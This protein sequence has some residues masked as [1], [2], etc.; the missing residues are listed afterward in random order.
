[1]E[2]RIGR[3]DRIGQKNERVLVWNYVYDETIEENIYERLGERISLFEQAVGPLRPILEGIEG[4]VQSIAMGESTKSG[5]DVATEAEEQSKK[6]EQ[7]VRQVGL[8]QDLDEI[9]PKDIIEEAKLYGWTSTHPDVGRIGYPGRPFDSLVTPDVLKRLFTQ[10]Q[11]LRNRGWRFEML[12][13]QLTEDEDAPYQKLYR[14]SIPESADP[15]ISRDP[16]ADTVQSMFADENEVLV[17]FD[18]EVL[19]WYPSVVIPLPQQ[20]LFEYLLDELLAELDGTTEEEVVRV[21]GDVA[22]NGTRVWTEPSAVS[23]ARVATYATEA[24]RRLSLDVPLPAVAA[25]REEVS[26]WLERYAKSVE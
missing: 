1:V 13:R 12:D 5:E 19:E 11:V 2:Q 16:L 4:E 6:A 26:L 9:R 17:S 15:P 7:K 23:D 22:E 20:E 14:L 10:S 21:A 3:I 18:P 24:Q 25:G 8:V